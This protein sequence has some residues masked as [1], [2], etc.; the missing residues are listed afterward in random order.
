LSTSLI[1]DPSSYTYANSIWQDKI[2]GEGTLKQ[3]L[4][5]RDK[6]GSYKNRDAVLKQIR[7]HYVDAAIK[8]AKLDHGISVQLPKAEKADK[9]ESDKQLR[10][11]AK[12]PGKTIPVNG[13]NYKIE[14]GFIIPQK[15]D[16]SLDPPGFIDDLNNKFPLHNVD[17]KGNK[18][19]NYEAFRSLTGDI[20]RKQ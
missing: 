12:N 11:L 4:G 19:L 7:N 10:A 1:D 20:G 2:N 8:K 16:L 17:K 9:Y 5:E 3:A 15:L 14:K 13:K 18:T 6:D